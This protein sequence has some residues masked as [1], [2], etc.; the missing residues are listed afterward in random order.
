[1]ITKQVASFDSERT[2]YPLV[3][4]VK[5]AAFDVDN[6]TKNYVNYLVQRGVDQN[7]IL[8][9][10]LPYD[11]NNKAL[12]KYQKAYLEWL[13]PKLI[14][15]GAKHIF[16]AD[17]EYFKTLTGLIHSEKH[18]GY[19]MPCTWQDCQDMTMTLGLNYTALYHNPN[20]Q[21]KMLMGLKTYADVVLNEY[22]SLGKGIIQS[23]RYLNTTTE[24]AHA[25]EMLHQYPMLAMDI[26]AFSLKFDEAGIGTIGFSWDENNGIAFACD[27]AVKGDGGIYV[28]NREVRALLKQFF[29]DYVGTPIWHNANYDLKVIVYT[30]WMEDYLDHAGMLEG[31]DIMTRSFHDTKLLNYCATNSVQRV[32]HDL[33][34]NTHE[35]AGNYAV[36]VKDISLQPLN[37]LLEYN[38]VDCLSTFWLFKKRFPQMR[39]DKQETAY[40]LFIDSVKVLL[41]MELVG[42]PMNPA[43]VDRLYADVSAQ[44]TALEH[45]IGGSPEGLQTLTL[46]KDAAVEAHNKVVKKDITLENSGRAQKLQF[47][48][49]NKNHIRTLVYDVL[50]LPVLDKTDSGM[51]SVKMKHLEKIMQTL[52]ASDPRYTMLTDI[53]E[54]SAM[55][56]LR[57]TFI[58]A[59]AKGTLKADG[60]KYLHGNY[61]IGGT[62]SGRLSASEP[63]LTNLPSGS[64]WGK[65][66]K[67]CV[68]AP[69]GWVF[70]GADFA[71]LEDR[72]KALLTQDPNMIKLYTEGY[73]GHALRMYHYWPDQ[74]KGVTET[75]EAVN[76]LKETHDELR[77]L[78]KAVTFALGYDGT[79]HTLMNN[80]GFSY[81]EA[82]G[83]YDN[84]AKLYSVSKQWSEDKKQEAAK[85]GYVDM[86]FGLRLRTPLLNKT[87]LNTRNT[88]Y[89]ATK[90]AKTLNNAASGQSY[91]LLTNR[92]M[93]ATM[94]RVW[95]SKYRLDILPVAMIHDA[96]Y[97][98]VRANTDAVKFLND[99][100]CE[101]MSWQEL[102]E[103]Q[104]ETVHLSAELELF[105][106]SWATPIPCENNSSEEAI[107]KKF[108]EFRHG[109]TTERAAGR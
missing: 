33:K 6:I 76:A 12:K 28:P 99:V 95:N 89:V 13:M 16:C 106:P 3:L 108:A 45:K 43:E 103:I 87:I 101:E 75:P 29:T 54:L 91:G 71:S 65:A 36:D 84:Y 2:S 92:S 9:V 38:L 35:F 97:F 79:P 5:E 61:K 10:P 41:Q 40:N 50:S 8:M 27:Y 60:R 104:H 55:G 59:F 100:L 37:K 4:L 86:A 109:T 102:S 74:F 83:I 15:F 68:Q 42:L 49:T 81:A 70:V 105:Y 96:N 7:E 47:S 82:H 26:E 77:S 20:Q 62:V 56:T 80:S 85:N 94:Q 107:Y 73:D 93:N 22:V 32:P 64:A 1:M 69:K 30:L 57:N 46:L 19:R 52:D 58:P 31:I 14:E 98:L 23:A 24:I 25:L 34:S 72:I 90:E 78:S 21:E 39:A 18:M 11:A 51:P 88:P 53:V 17:S 44:A 63:N 66:V 48:A 67:G